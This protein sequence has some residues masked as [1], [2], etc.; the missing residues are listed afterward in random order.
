MPL[1]QRR[2]LDAQNSVLLLRA[3]DFGFQVFQLLPRRFKRLFL[4]MTRLLFFGDG[5]RAAQLLL[6]RPLGF[7]GQ[8][9]EFQPRHRQAR[10]GAR[11]LLAELAPF[12]I[13]RQGILLL[14]LL[15][16]A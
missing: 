15:R 9:I 13:E 5:L 6:Q 8:A 10:I 11:Q 3:G 14:G 2:Q 4:P 1:L 7:F 16:G 12:M